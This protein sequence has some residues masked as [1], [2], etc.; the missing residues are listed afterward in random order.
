MGGLV[1][2]FRG[3]PSDMGLRPYGAPIT[4]PVLPKRDPAVEE[5]RLNAYHKSM[6]A[7]G[8]FWKLVWVHLF[9]CLG[10]AIVLIYIIPIAVEAGVDEVS[11]AGILSTLALVSA[12]TRFLTPVASEHLGAR[13]TMAT[14]F[15]L[16]GLPV[17]LLF[18]TGDVWQFYVFAV[19]FGVGYGGEGSGFPVMNRQSSV[20]RD[21]WHGPGRLERRRAVRDLWHFGMG[22]MGRSFG[23]QASGAMIGM[24]LGGWSG[25]VL[26][27]IFG[28]YDTTIL[29]SV[30]TSV[31]GGLI[32]LSMERTG[33]PIIAPWEET[34]A[35]EPRPSGAGPVPS[36]D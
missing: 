23:W 31:A 2:I 6:Q 5:M 35:P 13:R 27:A 29:L 7:T 14:M 17:L 24:A 11:A 12:L 3:Q 9:G 10:H 16:Q 19:V 26:Y 30:L 4:E 8:T 22:P 32:I 28:N 25:G 36:A 20:R 33:R 18:W 1:L 15:I 34:L 21:D